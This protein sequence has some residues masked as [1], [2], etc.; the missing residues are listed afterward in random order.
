MTAPDTDGD[1]IDN[2]FCMYVVDA[3]APG[4]VGV[5]DA[6]V[7][8]HEGF[9]WS[10]WFPQPYPSPEMCDAVKGAAPGQSVI[11]GDIQVHDNK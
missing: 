7:V 5:N 2:E 6:A 3:A 4:S 10:F 8:M 9:P 1:G 11:S